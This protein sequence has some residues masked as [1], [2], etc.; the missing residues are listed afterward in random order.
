MIGSVSCVTWS[1]QGKLVD[2]NDGYSLVINTGLLA[3]SGSYRQSKFSLAP[4]EAFLYASEPP[5]I[6][7]QGNDNW[8]LIGLPKRLLHASFPG[9]A[10]R[11]GLVLRHDPEV[12]RLL[13]SYLALFDTGDLPASLALADHVAATIVDLVG[14]VTGAKGDEA[15]LA[16]LTG[17]RAARLNAVLARIRADF[18]DPELSAERI[19]QKLGLSARYVQDLL[20]T[21][22]SGISERILERRLQ[23][24][25]TMLGDPRWA[26]MKI[27][28]IAYYVGFNDIS[29]FN[30]CFRRRFGD[31]PGAAR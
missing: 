30:R 15:E 23:R 16:G 18:S 8:L 11:Q 27:S 22:G 4:G 19:G 2:K 1:R 9:I 7:D 12:L 31:K 3:I 24:A 25:R 13:R 21:T 5:T 28:E 14:L 10:D 29:Y 20:A 17:L 6:S 26:A